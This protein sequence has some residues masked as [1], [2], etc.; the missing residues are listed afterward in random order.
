MSEPIWC[1]R[2]HSQARTEEHDHRFRSFK[3]DVCPTCG[4]IFFDKGEITK[5]TDDHHLERL[6]VDHAG[7]ASRLPCPRCGGAMS[8][9]L[10]GEVT[11]DVCRACH[12]VWMDRG[13]LE[14]A[15][16]TLGDKSDTTPPVLAKD[17]ATSTFLASGMREALVTTAFQGPFRPM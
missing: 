2:D 4:G 8:Q 7:G 11:I 13:E 15:V 6:I 10:V 12:G 5:L 3:L 14:T 9:R 17:L 16:R 1:P